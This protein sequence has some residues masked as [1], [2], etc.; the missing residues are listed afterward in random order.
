MKCRDFEAYWEERLK[1]Q[2]TGALE[3]HLRECP[4]CRELAGELARTSGWLALVQQE[5]PEASPA[6]WPRLRESIEERERGRDFWA[7]LGW[8]AGRAALALA[9]LVVTLTVGMVWQITHAEVA[10][11]DGPQVY[12]QE[13]PGSVPLPTNGRL[14]RDQVVQT[15]V[16][17]AEAKR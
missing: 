7:A 2:V 9:V 3:E 17:Q 5:P 16:L 10:E 8:A 11:F 13:A 15:L 14:N 4:R 12:L 1:G 6:F